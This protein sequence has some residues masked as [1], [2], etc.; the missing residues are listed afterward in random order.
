MY[1]QDIFL[2]LMKHM[3]IDLKPFSVTCKLAQHTY[4][5]NKNTLLNYKNYR[6]SP[7]QHQLIN[8][9]ATKTKEPYLLH[10]YNNKGKKSAIIMF[11][12][13]YGKKINIITNKKEYEKWYHEY[14]QVSEDKSLLIFDNLNKSNYNILISTEVKN[15]HALNIFYKADHPYIPRDHYVYIDKYNVIPKI[16]HI[17]YP[18]INT[19]NYINLISDNHEKKLNDMFNNIHFHYL[20][21]YIIVGNKEHH[22]AYMIQ[23]MN[24]EKIRPNTMYFVN[25]DKFT[26]N[27]MNYDRFKTF[28]ILWPESITT[29]LL[30]QVTEKLKSYNDKNII[31]IHYNDEGAFVE[32]AII[33]VN[34]DYTLYG[35]KLTSFAINTNKYMQMIHQLL[36]LHEDKLHQLPDDYFVL[37]MYVCKDDLKKVFELINDTLILK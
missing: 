22:Q 11:A 35:V 23:Y 1:N 6:F 27:K 17:Y 3:Y 18:C 20:G 30:S 4:Q 28:I 7:F 14:N 36:V 15:H 2:E 21:P 12:L 16:K 26:T 9:L 31:N 5:T 37:L 32:K 19:C 24:G 8:T 10:T 25:Y 33:N 34:T 29:M 13:L